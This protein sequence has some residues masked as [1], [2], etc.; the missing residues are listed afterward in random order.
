MAELAAKIADSEQE[1]E[2][3]LGQLAS[4]K[5]AVCREQSASHFHG[6]LAKRYHL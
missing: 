6:C 3:I 5:A 2:G 4:A 1:L